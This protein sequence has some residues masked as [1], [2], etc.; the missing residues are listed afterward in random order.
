VFHYIYLLYGVDKRYYYG[1][2]SCRCRPL[3][4]TYMGSYSDKTFSPVRKRILK[5]FPT[6]E[7]ALKEEVRIHHVRNVDKNIRY[8]NKAKQRTEKFYF[9]ASGEANPNYG[10]NHK[11]PEGLAKIAQTTRNRLLKN[12]EANPFC[13]RGVE[14]QSNGRRWFASPDKLEE[15]YL[16]KGEDPPE[17][18]IPGRKVRP[19][20]SEESRERT[21]MALKGK[22]KSESHRRKLSESLRKYN[23]S[24]K[25]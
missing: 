17:Q 22:T 19:P 25:E 12:P 23:L 10:G 1:V 13:K 5:T 16:K 18:W 2:R 9:A 11:S 7:E 21:R 24:L 20:R 15:V 14:S 4:D 6:R 8:A 3:E